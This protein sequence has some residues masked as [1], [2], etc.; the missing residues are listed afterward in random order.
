M[1]EEE[2]ESSPELNIL[3]ADLLDHEI[4]V[5]DKQEF[6]LKLEFLAHGDTLE[7]I[8]DQEFYFFIPSSLQINRRSYSKAHFYRDQTNL[9]RFKTPSYTIP[10]LLDPQKTKSPL[11][12][13]RK[14]LK[15]A[16]VSDHP[17][18]VEELKLFAN[19]IRSYV[20]SEVGKCLRM[21]NSGVENGSELT[22][23]ITSL[24]K[25]VAAVRMAIKDL[26]YEINQHVRWKP[27][28]YHLDYVDEFI[29]LMVESNL[30]MLLKQL[31]EQKI[32]HLE[33]TVTAAVIS[34]ATY[35]E[36]HNYQSRYYQDP[37]KKAEY[38]I[39]RRGLLKKYVMSVL[40]LSTHRRQVVQRYTHLVGAFAA[41][42]AMLFYLVFLLWWGGGVLI[43]SVPFVVLSVILYVIKD[44]IKEQVKSLFAQQASRWFPD[45]DIDIQAEDEGVTVGRLTEFCT[46][47]PGRKVPRWVHKLRNKD[48]HTELE[49]AKRQ[50][51]YFYYR[52]QITLYPDQLSRRMRHFH[53]NNVL[54]FNVS[55]FTRKASSAYQTTAQLNPETGELEELRCPKVY[56]VN[57][58]M[59][60][61]FHDRN[62]NMRSNL[63]EF[64]LVLDKRGIKRIE[65][66]N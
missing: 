18:L 9:V 41:A 1:L 55:D 20:R 33:E 60:T 24:V 25:E 36:E 43:N 29:S 19:V 57:V 5:R 66:V 15:D 42:L 62:D 59:R 35:R 12:Q 32:D 50:E 45:F 46:F 21:L 10:Q 63:K 64:R 34:E 51:K 30:T 39:Y 38:L 58:I 44:R 4:R 40:Q 7:S 23:S 28:A 22:E 53:L 2:E 47:L 49:R 65:S 56:H 6:E 16:P 61:R 3:I 37:D 11:Y 13:V 8:Y 52:R 54:R 48:F 17:L 31:K 14:I 26:N 27:H